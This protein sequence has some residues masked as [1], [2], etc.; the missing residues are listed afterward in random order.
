MK[1]NLERN[2]AMKILLAP[3]S[4]K[5]SMSASVA[6]QSMENG[7]RKIF[8]EALIVK[9]PMSDGGEGLL[10]SLVVAT[11]GQI[12]TVSVMG[13]LR[14][15]VQAKYGLLADHETAVIEIAQAC[16]LHL[17][18]KALRN[19][20][21]T[22]SYGVGQLILASLEHQPKRLIIG[23]G[24]S[25]TNDGG[26]GMLS[27]LGV[28]FT[29]TQGRDLRLGGGFLNQLASIDLSK[30]DPRLA[31][32]DITVACDVMNP[33][34]GSKGASLVYGPQKGADLLMVEI[35]DK[36]LKHYAS[37]LK[38]TINKEIDAVQGAGA[39]GGIGAALLGV[40]NGK[41]TSGISTVIQLTDF[42]KALE[43]TNLVL[44]GE[45]SIDDQTPYGKAVVGIAKAAK[46]HKVPVIAYA[47]RVS[48]DLEPLYRGGITSIITIMPDV[49]PL[50]EALRNGPQHLEAAVENTMRIL[51][52]IRKFK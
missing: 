37:V 35:L 51:Q 6:C 19:P 13:P 17:V 29:D 44:T 33:L 40:L 38:K 10:D 8:P 47:G 34:T 4:F 7:I 15:Q 50:G 43:D 22:T 45:G 11:N 25:A 42:E 46:R 3:D 49:M 39:A 52:N 9:M 32:L 31:N 1:S 24:G 18:P 21:A 12:H 2:Y 30:L 14:E 28:Q 16:G 41:L 27:A 48:G 36:N 23:L 5:E 26:A 20:F